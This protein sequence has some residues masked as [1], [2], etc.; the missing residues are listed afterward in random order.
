M[1]KQAQ[2]PKDAKDPKPEKKVPIQKGPIVNDWKTYKNATHSE[3]VT[4]RVEELRGLRS[5]ITPTM[6]IPKK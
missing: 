5:G 3:M 1:A 2:F 6:M 4:D